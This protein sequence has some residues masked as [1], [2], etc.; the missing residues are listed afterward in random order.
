MRSGLSHK[1]RGEVRSKN[2][3]SS[4]RR[5][6]FQ[7]LTQNLRPR[8]AADI[9]HVAVTGAGVLFD[10]AG[11]HDAA[12]KGYDLAVLLARGRAGRADIVLAARRALEPQFLRGGLVGQ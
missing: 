10:E 5:F 7:R 11:D 4:S 9:D 2:A 3:G 1:G 8:R 12:V 6:S